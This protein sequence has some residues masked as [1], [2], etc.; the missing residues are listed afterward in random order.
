MEIKIVL[1]G[2]SGVIGAT[3]RRDSIQ[4]YELEHLIRRAWENAEWDSHY[5]ELHIDGTYICDDD[6]LSKLDDFVISSY[7]GIY[8]LAYDGGN[9][10]LST[11]N[12]Q[13]ISD[14]FRR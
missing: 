5:A 8:T 13:N 7:R 1:A 11:T 2:A 6:D 9:A 3:A 4:S 10:E 12:L 14:F